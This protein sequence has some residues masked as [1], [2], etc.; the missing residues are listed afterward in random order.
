MSAT[1]MRFNPIGLV[2][3]ALELAGIS[4]PDSAAVLDKLAARHDQTGQAVART[5]LGGAVVAGQA[6]VEALR[7][8]AGMMR[9]AAEGLRVTA[10]REAEAANEPKPGTVAAEVR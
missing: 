10:K 7:A 4:K 3:D 1:D 9:Q 5:A 8:E 2:V 6:F